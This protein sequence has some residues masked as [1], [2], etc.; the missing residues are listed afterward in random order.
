VVTT[1]YSTIKIG[2]FDKIDNVSGSNIIK[3]VLDCSTGQLCCCSERQWQNVTLYGQLSARIMSC[4]HGLSAVSTDYQLSAQTVSTDY[5]LSAQTI[6][7]Q[8]GQSAVSMDYQHLSSR[9]C[10]AITRVRN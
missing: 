6:S 7:C 4:Q 9:K 2:F 1:L 10:P 8:H 5:Q 3:K